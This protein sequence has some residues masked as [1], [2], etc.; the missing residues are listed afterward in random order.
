MVPERVV[1]TPET[2]WAAPPLTKPEI[3]PVDALP[4]SRNVPDF[5]MRPVSASTV[6]PTLTTPLAVVPENVPAPELSKSAVS[7]K[8][9]LLWP[10]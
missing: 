7:L 5:E 6:T 3:S 1:K 9:D 4:P 10:L 2:D 8:P